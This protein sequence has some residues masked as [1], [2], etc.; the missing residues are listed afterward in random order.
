MSEID[1]VFMLPAEANICFAFTCLT[2]IFLKIHWSVKPHNFLAFKLIL[3]VNKSPLKMSPFTWGILVVDFFS[4]T[5]TA[6]LLNLEQNSV[7]FCVFQPQ[8]KTTVTAHVSPVSCWAT[9]RR[10][11]Y[12]ALTQPCLSKLWPHCSGGICAKA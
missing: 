11:W 4:L 8:R 9:V 6:V 10:E 2:L 5:I 1:G 7:L 3:R 12:T